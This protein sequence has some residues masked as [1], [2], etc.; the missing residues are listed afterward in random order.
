MRAALLLAL[1]SIPPA[2]AADS[3]DKVYREVCA[4]CHETK[5]DKAPQLG[6]RQAWAPLIKEGQHILT[7]HAWVGVRNMPAR[8]GS[9]DLG[10]EEFAR[11]VAYMARAAG[12]KWQDPDKAMLDRIGAE[13]SKRLQEIGEQDK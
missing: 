3:G 7:A 10:L 8:G 4:A 13:V 12:G 11:A 6:D 1:F 5:F 2:L 9:N